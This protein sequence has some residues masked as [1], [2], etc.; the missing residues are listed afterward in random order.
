ML[1]PGEIGLNFHL[2]RFLNLRGLASSLG[3]TKYRLE[4]YGILDRAL[5]GISTRD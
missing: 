2:I 3:D 4:S 5:W 1:S